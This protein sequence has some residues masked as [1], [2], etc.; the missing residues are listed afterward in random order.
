MVK[1]ARENDGWGYT[2]IKGAL[3]NLGYKV[4][5]GTI[6]RI[7]RENGIDPAPLRGMPWG[8]F[9]KAHLGAIVG[10]DFLTV[11]VVT[12]LGLV[13]YHVLFVIDIE[14][15]RVEI[16]GIG[17]DPC[18][19]WMEQMARNLVDAVDGF[20]A[21]KRYLLMDRD[22]LYTGPFRQIVQGGGV[23]IVRL[24]ARSPNLNAFAERFVL[25]I[26]SEC[27]DRLVPLGERHLRLAIAEYMRHYHLERNHQGLANA[28]INGKLQNVVGGS[29]VACRERLGGLLKFYHRESA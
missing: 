6:Q 11:E 8:T 16:A 13:R 23:K 3:Q 17:R 28:L 26:K 20:L 27:L 25:S 14:S 10:M 15:R 5:R 29:A 2:R 4:G 7:L 24:P 1:M 9:I 18:G 19:R 22:P 12:L 21:G